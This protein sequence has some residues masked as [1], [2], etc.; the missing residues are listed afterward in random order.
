M[1]AQHQSCKGAETSSW[2]TGSCVQFGIALAY[3]I[4][5]GL[6]A[7]AA[8]SDNGW[9]WRL[10]LGLQSVFSVVTIMLALFLPGESQN[11]QAR[12]SHRK[13]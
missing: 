9:A 2:S 13:N 6:A 11:L 12:R 7:S 3:W 5:Y 1:A 4:D 8:T 10:P